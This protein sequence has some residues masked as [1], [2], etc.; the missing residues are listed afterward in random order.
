[1]IYLHFHPV[2]D[3]DVY[4]EHESLVHESVNNVTD[5][6]ERV[7][8][9]VLAMLTRTGAGVVASTVHICIWRWAKGILTK[10]R[11]LLGSAVHMDTFSVLP[12]E[13]PL[14]VPHGY[15]LLISSQPAFLGF[16]QIRT[17]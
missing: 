9:K 4:T 17:C 2:D 14:I 6:H 12:G 16:S 5:T 15:E 7:V 10:L 1:M 3:T 13:A 8:L 11:V